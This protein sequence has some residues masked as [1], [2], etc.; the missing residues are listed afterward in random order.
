[1][2]RPRVKW[3]QA[4]RFFTRRGYEI[5]GAGGEKMVIAPK[6][7][8]S[9]RTRNVVRVGHHSCNS[10]GSEILPCYLQA[11]RRAFNVTAEDI[12]ND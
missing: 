3:G 4:E 12:L 8:D 10:A 11:F 9:T 1:M 5:R 2:G 7:P 6:T